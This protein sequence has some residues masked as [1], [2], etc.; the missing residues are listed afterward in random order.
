[1]GLQQLW[2]RLVC[3]ENSFEALLEPHVG[4]LYRLAYHFC[5]D[6][7]DAEDLVQDLLTKLFARA[8]DLERLDQLRPW[9]ARVLY[10]MYVD[11]YRSVARSPVL[12]AGATA[13]GD[14]DQCF[15]PGPGPEHQAES[16]DVQQRLSRALQYLNADQRAVVIL[17]DIEGYTLNELQYVLEVPVGTLKSRLNRAHAQLRQRLEAEQDSVEPFPTHQRL[18]G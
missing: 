14:A 8:T 11:R 13:T 7:D 18:I 17:H 6:Q 15:H 12:R 4:Y 3:R 2:A 5:G 1:M 10:R 9:L 16:E